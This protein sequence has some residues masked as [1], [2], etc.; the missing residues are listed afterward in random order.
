LIFGRGLL[1]YVTMAS[2]VAV[3]ALSANT[4]FADFPRLCRILAED[5][6]LPDFFAV[7]ERR[8]VYS[9]GILLLALLAG[10]LLVGFGGLSQAGMVGHWLRRS[11]PAA[12]YALPLNAAGAVATGVTLV[13]VAV[14]EFSDG[15]W[16]TL[17]VLPLIV[18]GFVRINGHYHAVARQIATDI[19][20]AVSAPAKS[21]VIVAVQAWN[22]LTERGLAFGLRLSPD[23]Y[24]V[25]VQ[26]EISKMRDLGPDWERLVEQPTRAAGLPVPRLVV[27]ASTYRRFFKPLVDFVLNIRDDNPS[28]DIV[29]IVPDLVMSHWYH[30]LFHNSRR[31]V[32]GAL[33]RLR[34]GPRVIVVATPFHLHD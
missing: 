8:L 13:V 4:S 20:L 23:V 14:S 22:K 15:A 21:I 3:L 34:G 27:L 32:L 25:Q 30:A 16:L 17:V 26:A 31:A 2:V 12:R 7:R 9:Q 10:V 5:R 6:F 29:V 1:Y 28:R 11:G 33:L 19:P 24:A 18:W